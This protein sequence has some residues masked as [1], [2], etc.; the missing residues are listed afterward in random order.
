MGVG[1]EGC[2][3]GLICFNIMIC[4]DPLDAVQAIRD[5][6]RE[7]FL[8]KKLIEGIFCSYH[9]YPLIPFF[10]H[11]VQIHCSPPAE[12][13]GGSVLACHHC[14]KEQPQVKWLG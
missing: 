7:K 2:A 6:V 5:E 3:R 12:P 13:V 1:L 9:E 14:H 11:M 8:R 10:R 4:N